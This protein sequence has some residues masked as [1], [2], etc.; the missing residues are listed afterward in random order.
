MG[1]WTCAIVCN[2]ESSVGEHG[3]LDVRHWEG[4]FRS[5]DSLV[6]DTLPYHRLFLARDAE[7]RKR[8]NDEGDI[9]HMING[10][11]LGKVL[12]LRGKDSDYSYS[13][14]I[15]GGEFSKPVLFLY[16]K[17]KYF[18]VNEKI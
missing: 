17:D 13:L 7:K 12:I 11:L 3:N 18:S 2:V 15:F 9:F 6:S 1:H 10:Y 16:K 14:Q 5:A 8:Q 4:S